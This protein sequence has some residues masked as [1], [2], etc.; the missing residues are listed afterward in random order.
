M[1]VTLFLGN[2]KKKGSK[3]M[4]FDLDK[5]YEE[6]DIKKEPKQVDDGFDIFSDVDNSDDES[7]RKKSDRK[8]DRKR[9]S[10][11]R[12]RKERKRSRERR[13]SK[14][15]SR[16][17]NFLSVNLL[18]YL[19]GLD[20]KRRKD[21]KEERKKSRDEPGTSGSS[22][23]PKYFDEIEK[24]E[25]VTTDVSMKD[26][27]KMAKKYDKKK[28]TVDKTGKDGISFGEV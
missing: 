2:K 19:L 15:R 18:I 17:G 11:S 23:K 13:R 6:K 3:K 5:E 14:D 20:K 10:R 9:R 1:T 24:D 21:S 25:V 12:D 28:T 27:Q 4:D 7:S 26:I 8:K 22:E 16:D